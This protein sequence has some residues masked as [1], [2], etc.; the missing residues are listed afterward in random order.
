MIK[1][2][3]S[4]IFTFITFGGFC[5]NTPAALGDSLFKAFQTNT[6]SQLDKLIPSVDQMLVIAKSFT[7]GQSFT[8]DDVKAFKEKYPEEKK[9]FIVKCQQIV[10][11]GKGLGINWQNIQAKDIKNIPIPIG[12]SEDQTDT[13]IS[14]KGI[15]I[16]FA[17]GNQSFQLTLPIAVGLGD[18]W[19]IGD[20][21][22]DLTALKK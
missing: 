12:L 9:K 16:L 20:N 22:I 8:E 1:P 13:K 10:E 4:I 5:Q 2:L 7:A 18:K 6:I 21:K 19:Y 17:S 3:F 14:L 15:S 11:E